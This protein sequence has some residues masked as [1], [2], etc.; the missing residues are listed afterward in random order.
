MNKTTTR[1][2]LLSIC[3]CCTTLVWGNTHN[4]SSDTLPPQLIQRKAPGT[5][6]TS[7]AILL[8]ASGGDDYQWSTGARTSSINIDA[9][10]SPQ[11][12]SVHIKRKKTAENWVIQ[13]TIYPTNYA[14]TSASQQLNCPAK[15]LHWKSAVCAGG[16]VTLSATG[17]LSYKWS[18]NETTSS[19]D[20][21]PTGTEIYTVTIT[22]PQGCGVGVLNTINPIEVIPQPTASIEG[23][24]GNHCGLGVATLV[25]NAG[26][27]VTGASF[28]W[29]T[30]QTTSTIN[31][32]TQATTG[33]G[34]R[35]STGGGL[36][37]SEASATINVTPFSP[38]V[39]GASQICLGTGTVLTASGGSAYK[40]ENNSASN[41][42]LVTPSSAG[43]HIYTVTITAGSCTA[44]RSHAVTVTP[45]PTAT[46]LGP[47]KA[48]HNGSITLTAS[49]T[50]TYKWSTG[51]TTSSISP[52]LLQSNQTYGLTI[53]DPITKC[54][55]ADQH[56]VIVLERP[57]LNDIPNS[58]CAGASVN[59]SVSGG[60]S[61][62]WNVGGTTASIVHS[63]SEFTEYRVTVTDANGCVYSLSKS[64]NVEALPRITFG[65][66]TSICAGQSLNV[67]AIG[68]QNYRWDYNNATTATITVSPTQNTTYT[69]T[70]TSGLGCVASA[71]RVISIKPSPLGN[72]NDAPGSICPGQSVTL[73]ASG[74]STYRWTEGNATTASITVSPTQNTNY[75]V[76]IT[77]T[78]GCTVVKSHSIAVN[79]SGLANNNGP[80]TCSKTTVTLLGTSS[81]LGATYRWKNASGVEIAT[82]PNTTVSTPGVYTLE[83]SAAGGCT[84][85]TATEVRLDRQVP[86][87]N[88]SNNGVIT[89]TQS[90]V[91][92]LGTSSA[93]PASYEWRNNAG[94]LIANTLNASTTQAGTYTLKVTAA[95]GCSGTASTT[96]TADL[97]T[98]QVN[99]QQDGP[100]TCT[101]TSVT[102]NA[103][104]NNPNL[105]YTWRNSGGSIIAS[106]SSSVVVTATGTYQLEA[107]GS[108]GCATTASATITQSG[109]F[110][111]ISVNNPG[112]IS[113]IGPEATISG[114]STTP[115]VTYAWYNPN[116][117]LMT[118]QKSFIANIAGT[119]TLKV[120]SAE[121]CVSSASTTLGETVFGAQAIT[122]NV[123]GNST[124]GSFAQGEL[125]CT[126]N[127]V[128]MSASARLAGYSISVYWTNA[129]GTVLST[130]KQLTV[131]SPG[132][133]YLKQ[134]DC[135][136]VKEI[137]IKENRPVPVVQIAGEKQACV[138]KSTTL[139]ASGGGQYNWSSGATSSTISTD[140]I[141]SPTTYTVT[142]ST[143][144]YCSTVAN[145]TVSNY[146]SMVINIAGETS[147]CAGTFVPLTASGGYTYKWSHNNATT[148]SI[149]VAPLVPTTY[150]VTA[151][152]DKGCTAIK[153]HVISTVK[154]QP[155][156][157]DL[158]GLP[159]SAFCGEAPLNISVVNPIS[160]Y[161]WKWSTGET[162]TFLQK[163]LTSSQTISVTATRNNGCTRT[164][165]IPITVNTKPAGLIQGAEINCAGDSTIL[166]APA[167]ETY[168]WST[169]ASTQSIVV[170]PTSDQTY[171]VTVSNAGG[172]CSASFE[173]RVTVP[174]P[175]NLSHDLAGDDDCTPN[176]A[177]VIPIVSGGTG[178]ITLGLIRS[179]ELYLSPN[180]DGLKSGT[181]VLRAVDTKG[182]LALDE[183]VIQ[184]TPI[185]ISS[186][187]LSK[188]DDCIPGNTQLN[189][190]TKGDRLP[191]VYRL[192]GVVQ[193]GATITLPRDER[194]YVIEVADA[195]GCVVSREEYYEDYDAV[196]INT[197]NTSPVTDCSTPNGA[198]HF[199]YVAKPGSS[200]SNFSLSVD[201]GTTWHQGV[202][203]VGNLRPGM[204]QTAARNDL[205]GCVVQGPQVQINA[206]YCLPE[207]GFT[208][209]IL[210]ITS[211]TQRIALPWRV[212]KRAWGNADK[213]FSLRIY[214]EGDGKPH[215]V[216]PNIATVTEPLEKSVEP[217][218]GFTVEYAVDFEGSDERELVLQPNAAD[219]LEPGFYTFLM[220]GQGVDVDPFRKK[221]TVIVDL[222]GRVIVDPVDAC[223]GIDITLTVE[224]GECWNW[225]GLNQPNQRTITVKHVQGRIY[226]VHYLENLVKKTK[227][228][229]G[230]DQI[231]IPVKLTGIEEM[232]PGDSYY[233]SWKYK[234]NPFPTQES[235]IYAAEW[236]VEWVPNNTSEQVENIPNSIKVSPTETT[237]YKILVTYIP[238]GCTF[239]LAHTVEVDDLFEKAGIKAKENS[240]ILCYGK[241]VVLDI[242]NPKNVNL[243]YSWTSDNGFSSYSKPPLKVNVP[244]K[245]TLELQWLG[246]S[247]K[248]IIEFDVK[249]NA[250]CEIKEYFEKNGFYAIPIEITRTT[251]VRPELR[252]PCQ[253]SSARVQ[254]DAQ[255]GFTIQNKEVGS[256]Q[257]IL[258]KSLKA[259]EFYGYTDSKALISENTDLCSCDDYLDFAEKRFKQNGLQYWSHVFDGKE[260]GGQDFL[261]IKAKMPNGS[262][263]GSNGADFLNAGLNYGLNVAPVSKAG[264][265]FAMKLVIE[266][267]LD[268]YGEPKAP[269]MFSTTPPQKV[270]EITGVKATEFQPACE[271][272]KNY[273]PVNVV[274]ASGQLITLPAQTVWRFGINPEIQGKITQGILSGYST[275][276][277][278]NGI[279]A[280]DA[281]YSFRF[282]IGTTKSLGYFQSG[283]AEEA[284]DLENGSE[285][286]NV[287]LTD[288]TG[289]VD[290]ETG[291]TLQQRFSNYADCGKSFAI[292]RMTLYPN[293][294]AI[295][296]GQT[297]IKPKGEFWK[298]EFKELAL[299][300]HNEILFSN[301]PVDFYSI[302][303][304]A[305]GPEIAEVG[306]NYSRLD[307][308]LFYNSAESSMMYKIV[309]AQGVSRWIYVRSEPGTTI[310]GCQNKYSYY[311]WNCK[312]GVW[313]LIDPKDPRFKSDCQSIQSLFQAFKAS[314]VVH[315]V[316]ST[317]GFIPILGD[318]ASLANGLIY[319]AEGDIGR[320]K[321]EIFWAV[322]GIAGEIIPVAG[323]GL[324]LL[325]STENV[326][327]TGFA[328]ILAIAKVVPCQGVSSFVGNDLVTSSCFI[329]VRILGA[330]RTRA[331]VTKL[332]DL[333][334]KFND[335]SK[336]VTDFIHSNKW[337]DEFHKWLETVNVEDL[338][339]VIKTTLDDLKLPKSKLEDIVGDLMDNPGLLAKMAKNADL[340][341]AWDVLSAS[342]IFRQNEVYLKQLADLGFDWAKLKSSFATALSKGDEHVR[343]WLE[344]KIPQ[345]DL[346]KAFKNGLNDTPGEYTP[347]SPEH[348]AQRWEQYKARHKEQG[349]TP[350]PY[351]TWSN[352]FDGG[353][354]RTVNASKTVDD[355]YN[356]NGWMKPPV[357]KE[358]PFKAEEVGTVTRTTSKGNPVT[359]G[360]RHDIYDANAKKATEIK[361]YSD[362]VYKTEDIEM[363]A[364]K[365]AHMLQEKK[366]NE[367][368]WLFKSCAAPK[369]CG[370]S[371][372]LQ[373]FLNDLGIKWRMI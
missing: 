264:G 26:Q 117:K 48:C 210:H 327:G 152:S 64:V 299:K 161:T 209:S 228:F 9:L 342:P 306:T 227:I 162:T 241:D 275:F 307:V 250:P 84:F 160:T 286:F 42:R 124:N 166:T 51:A 106:N 19:I 18:T 115:G 168:L 148:E 93:S 233:V 364:L 333:G 163:T 235:S 263:Y 291:T 365:D 31:F 200:Q 146:P 266:G 34:V 145:V 318:L 10:T 98:P 202:N 62:S 232:C 188:V 39:Q 60:S 220:E 143:G 259:F 288:E 298:K 368:E 54:S 13:Q 72:I 65:G 155:N 320:G 348:K 304:E 205:T 6:L 23:G 273:Y 164:K 150:T 314:V 158:N 175:L 33:V 154:S 1:F 185:E 208:Q 260:C 136:L 357:Y 47:D 315:E 28:L 324:R 78:E 195:A 265:K 37:S 82:T 325:K 196:R 247:C 323:L 363:E 279:E 55:S 346:E 71:Q 151:T 58:I 317:V 90:S 271:G 326:L 284:R 280:I 45:P 74:G 180:L 131:S 30:G 236:R 17:G 123:G 372:P 133:Y 8:Q 181:Y 293:I 347:Y 50:G 190:S 290:V 237:T 321:T 177:A 242:E 339:V 336:T 373:N 75:T 24:G 353:I 91:N 332:Q 343:K 283:I 224:E 344:L 170:K 7:N 218:A 20:V 140:F 322:V 53:T 5:R 103:N 101:K 356:A 109:N 111:N 319:L 12:Y 258:S 22:G 61:Y 176:N 100:L 122:L 191:L 254:D 212:D 159:T 142:V 287:P 366:L 301:K 203:L 183:V 243:G 316:L 173:K 32:T 44:V 107:R 57:T 66:G 2:L 97:A 184:E 56:D 198:I 165:A 149:N 87:V 35:V 36:C 223:P 116:G 296:P 204:Y 171:R 92:L 38:N 371:V 239:E 52:S 292:N 341:K 240:K 335:F 207:A 125:T 360:R 77:N 96:V 221:L 79:I 83:I 11:K 253:E 169:G 27:G 337:G 105:Q 67:T 29:S 278:Y 277:N 252:A 297:T 211:P 213:P 69:V 134:N 229:I 309:N 222:D 197:A 330:D 230:D 194:T 248:K 132:Y 249:S 80:L 119:Y 274:S 312:I 85:T 81:A 15:E 40:W 338:A 41:S 139:T 370:P 272:G 305:L 4:T 354:D 138:G 362:K 68:G 310:D 267:M 234:D 21:V 257:D 86:I 199:A 127:S 255:M 114:N 178:S 294:L 88:A 156:N 167:G 16:T 216:D 99:I 63:P 70:A 308:N 14:N 137:L 358:Y 128:S 289:Y 102:L 231:D 329:G 313:Q 244:G 157:F 94:N 172:T 361:D 295:L 104:P 225:E 328:K 144:T 226:K 174:A 270:P 276:Q 311:I 281:I 147:L 350:D 349:T 193:A 352:G 118:T 129:A 49:G 351:E 120:T 73:I 113:C 217:G 121:G 302:C 340:I 76:S 219:H 214:R 345:A 189:I 25:A 43:T 282:Y 285:S 89:C 245:Y 95:N 192:D 153:T 179:G 186:L 355:Y 359:G 108:N 246:K 141:Y 261:F 112:S 369:D 110:P 46:I 182:C 367:V 3:M 126:Q 256:L 187:T 300:V 130:T 303:P 201:G 269:E 268:N 331:L 238:T 215:F 59:L 206:P 135:P 251:V 334:F 262:E